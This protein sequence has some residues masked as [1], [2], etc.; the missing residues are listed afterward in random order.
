MFSVFKLLYI[1]LG[2]LN[3]QLYRAYY[4]INGARKLGRNI[5]LAPIGTEDQVTDGKGNH[6]KH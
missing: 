4:R 2:I 1:I 5:N 6:L 3:M